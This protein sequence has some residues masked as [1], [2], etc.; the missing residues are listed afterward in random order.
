MSS[1][2][3]RALSVS[4][5]VVWAP[6]VGISFLNLPRTPRCYSAWS[7]VGAFRSA[8]IGQSR[9]AFAW[10]VFF[11]RLRFLPW[12]LLHQT[13]PHRPRFQSGRGCRCASQGARVV[14]RLMHCKFEPSGCV[15]ALPVFIDTSRGTYVCGECR[16]C[17]ESFAG[18]LP[19][20]LGRASPWPHPPLH[21]DPVGSPG[22]LF[23]IILHRAATLCARFSA[24]AH[25]G[26]CLPWRRHRSVPN[27]A[28]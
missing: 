28:V 1:S 5:T 27:A 2:S 8:R 21:Q 11:F 15:G 22:S 10:G 7:L 3:P 23:S 20:R 17:W 25:L 18:L 13:P 9:C 6:L 26:G 24:R 16:G 14:D 12:P 4:L 19:L